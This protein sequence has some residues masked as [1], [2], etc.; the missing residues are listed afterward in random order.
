MKFFNI[1]I[2]LYCFSNLIASNSI[3]P[4]TLISD[5]IEFSVCSYQNEKIKCKFLCLSKSKFALNLSKLIRD[6]LN[7]TDQLDVDLKKYNKNLD[8]K[9]LNKFFEK[10]IS[11][12]IFLNEDKKIKENINVKI[13]DT[14][15]DEIL[16]DQNFKVDKKTVVLGAHEI[17]SNVLKKLTDGDKGPYLSSIAYCKYLNSNQKVV[18]VSDYSC[19]QTKIAVDTKA[20]NVAPRWH[21]KL[22]IL[23]Y[24]LFFLKPTGYFATG[25]DRVVRRAQK[26]CLHHNIHV[27]VSISLA[28]SLTILV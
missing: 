7:S 18:C 3:D 21:S 5:D 4:K 16:F 6:D 28:P 23:Y 9:V 19:N 24:V 27:I 1:I 11:L 14:D 2:F 13:K 20:I 22:P 10:D 8:K 15:S 26:T 12:F 17:A 25:M